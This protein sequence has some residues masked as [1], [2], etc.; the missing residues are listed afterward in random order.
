MFGSFRWGPWTEP[1]REQC[2]RILAADRLAGG[3]R[4]EAADFGDVG[5]V[6]NE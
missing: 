6:A 2:V 4:S 1:G 5:D 3:A